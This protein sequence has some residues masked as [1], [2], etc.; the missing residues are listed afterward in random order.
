VAAGELIVETGDPTRAERLIADW[1]QRQAA[2]IF[3]QRLTVCFERVRAWG[4]AYPT[5]RVRR[6][7]TRWG[8]CTGHGA[9]TLNSR[10]VELPVDLI[11]YVIL[12]ELCHLR[13]MNH[14]PRFY[15]LLEGV[16]PTWKAQRAAYEAHRDLTLRY[17]FHLC[18]SHK[19]ACAM[20]TQNCNRDYNFCNCIVSRMPVVR[21]HR[22]LPAQFQKGRCLTREL[23]SIGSLH[24]K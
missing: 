13:E 6:M 19:L 20:F 24:S 17:A 18:V 2:Q 7:K 5:L 8:S 23:R 1:Y 10:L 9:I 16:C 15:A 22:D 4:V 12:H 14:G 11:D 3:S 21:A